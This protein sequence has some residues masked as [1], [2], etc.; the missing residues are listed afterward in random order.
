M[1][2]HLF[3]PNL[4]SKPIQPKPLTHYS[5]ESQTRV[6]QFELTN[7]TR[8]WPKLTNSTR[9]PELAELL[10]WLVDFDQTIDFYL[11]RWLW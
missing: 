1:C 5:F 7:P 9:S 2:D 4:N 11:D 8:M 3:K 6:T 10:T